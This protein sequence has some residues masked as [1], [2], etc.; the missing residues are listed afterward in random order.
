MCEIYFNRKTARFRTASLKCIDFCLLPVGPAAENA[1]DPQEQVDEIKIQLECAVYCEISAQCSDAAL[2]AVVELLD[3]LHVPC[4]D[5]KEQ[6][7]ADV[8]DDQRLTQRRNEDRSDCCDNERNQAADEQTAEL[9][10]IN[11]CRMADDRAAEEHDCRKCKCGEY[12][13]DV[14]R[15]RKNRE[16]DTGE[17]SVGIEKNRRGSC[18]HLCDAH[19]QEDAYT[20]LSDHAD[21]I[22]DAYCAGHIRVVEQTAVD[23]THISAERNCCCDQDRNTHHCKYFSNIRI[24]SCTGL[25]YIS[26]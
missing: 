6:E 24:Q 16:C 26:L 13:R 5:D 19:R 12:C 10:E 9:C 8:A 11:A 20:E 15:H 14:K 21:D 3:L 22:T 25:I 7:N 4:R 1:Q 17:R 18:L 2:C 23:K